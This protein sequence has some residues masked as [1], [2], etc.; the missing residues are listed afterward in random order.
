VKDVRLAREAGLNTPLVQ[1][2]VA[3]FEKAQN[4]EPGDEEVL[5]I[6]KII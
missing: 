4:E 6:I 2:L 1:P 5:V 3:S